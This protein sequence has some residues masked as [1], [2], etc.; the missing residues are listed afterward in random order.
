MRGG[1][2]RMVKMEADCRGLYVHVPFCLSKCGYCA[3]S[4]VPVRSELVARYLT[5]LAAEA[6]Q[7]MERLRARTIYVGGGTPTVLDTEAL[8]RLI[9]IIADHVVAE[10]VE[11]WT[12]EANPAT[13]M[14]ERIGALTKAG[15]TRVSLGVQSFSDLY[16]GRLGRPHSASDAREAARI[17]REAGLELSIDLMTGL[18][19]QSRREAERDLEALAEIRPGHASVYLLTIE[20]GTPFAREVNGGKMTPIEDDEAADRMHLAH[21]YLCTQ[22]YDHYE[23]SNFALPRKQCKHNLMYW[24]GGTYLGIGPAAASHVDGRRFRNPTDLAEYVG[25]VKTGWREM[26]VERLDARGRARERLMLGLRLLTG[27]EMCAFEQETGVSVREIA[28]RA[29]DDLVEDGFLHLEGGRLALT[30]KGLPV[31]DAVLV[32]LL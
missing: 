18:P 32:E 5:A 11:E 29:L 3:F 12:V 1:G 17:V 30:R 22:G 24:H 31:A 2:G 14:G 15:V 20:E 21:D 6:G 28:G 9:G 4:S 16:L 8:E 26:E 23:I 19:G 27:I 13:E 7:R 10:A 25:L